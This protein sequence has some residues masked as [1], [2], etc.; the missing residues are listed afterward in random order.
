MTIIIDILKNDPEWINIY[1]CEYSNINREDVVDVLTKM[2]TQQF[3]F[4]FKELWID[5]LTK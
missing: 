1:G 4:L 3:A 2:T 5:W